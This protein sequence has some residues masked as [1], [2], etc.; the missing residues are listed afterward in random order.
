MKTLVVYY[1]FEGNTR[2]IANL[3]ATHVKADVLELKVIDDISGG[4]LA[5]YF[6]GGRQVVLGIKPELAPFSIDVQAYDLIFIGTPVWAFSYSP[7]MATFFDRVR[8]SGKKIALFCCHGGMKGRV[9]DTMRDQL[10]GNDIV[11][12]AD[13]TDSYRRKCGQNTEKAKAFAADVLA[14]ANT[15]S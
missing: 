2:Y 10:V 11:A 13:F 15:T 12:E 8:F 7:A 14:G 9:F 5:K 6:W 4:G 1:S 3:I